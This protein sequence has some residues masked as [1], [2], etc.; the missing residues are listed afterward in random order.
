MRRG[1]SLV[2]IA[3]VSISISIR[4]TSNRSGRCRHVNG[5]SISSRVAVLVHDRLIA[6]S[7][8]ICSIRGAHISRCGVEWESIG[9]LSISEFGVTVI[10]LALPEF[11]LRRAGCVAIVWRW[12]KSALF[13]AVLDEAVLDEDGEEEE[14]TRLMLTRLKL[15]KIRITYAPTM[16]TAKQA[17]FNLHA[18]CR[19]G[20]RVKPLLLFP[21]TITVFESA[22]PV[23]RGVLMIPRQLPRPSRVA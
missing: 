6:N 21:T 18:M 16:A 3:T 5:I 1:R 7:G 2:S 19:D 14:D 20:R 17:V 13:A 22:F 4:S 15:K 9:F 10:G 11:A 23:P 12:A 8:G